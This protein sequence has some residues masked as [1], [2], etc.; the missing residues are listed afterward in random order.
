[1]SGNEAPRRV[2]LDKW[3]WA[4]R[5]FKTRAKAKQA[6]EGGK[7]ECEG[8]R[9][10]PA[11]EIEVGTELHIRQGFDQRVVHVR[12]LSEQRRG[13]SEAQAMY[14]ETA[15]SIAAREADAARR[16]AQREAVELPRG[17]PDRRDRRELTDIKKRGG[18]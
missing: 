2:R 4:A 1:M 7:V 10:K 6:I 14:E 8:Q 11:K 12:A 9:A 15:D 5:F 3:L 13:A 16:K 17:R 18:L